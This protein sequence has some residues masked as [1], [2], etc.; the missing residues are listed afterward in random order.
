MKRAIIDAASRVIALA[1]SSKF[2]EPSFSLICTVDAVD[3]SSLTRSCRPTSPE[4]QERR[5]HLTMV[6]V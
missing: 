2:Q 3:R 1:D 6:P 5:H 4:Y